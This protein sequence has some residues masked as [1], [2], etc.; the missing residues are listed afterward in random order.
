MEA[1]KLREPVAERDK[2]DS[3]EENNVEDNFVIV[4]GHFSNQPEGT[5]IIFFFY[6]A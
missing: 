6:T 1:E 4:E 5:I 2:K 3:L